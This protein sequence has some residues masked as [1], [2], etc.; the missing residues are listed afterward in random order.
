[1]TKGKSKNVDD[2]LRNLE[3]RVGDIEKRMERSEIRAARESARKGGALRNLFETKFKK[4]EK[5]REV[6]KAID[7]TRG[8]QEI[9]RIAEMREN[10]VRRETALFLHEGLI[11][12]LSLHPARYRITA[13]GKQIL[14][15]CEELDG[16]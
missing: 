6:L 9:A 13:D 16:K 7:P 15:L 11:E 5:R 12:K 14:Q 1:M 3:K 2:T 8:N 4:S 10:N